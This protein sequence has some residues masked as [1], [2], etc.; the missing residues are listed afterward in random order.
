MNVFSVAE[1]TGMVWEITNRNL[2][3]SLGVVGIGSLC[4]APEAAEEDERLLPALLLFVF[5]FEGVNEASI[6]EI[7]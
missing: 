4:G 6:W 5:V 2:D 7:S 1:W 3:F